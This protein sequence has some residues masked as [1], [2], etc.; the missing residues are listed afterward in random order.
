[1]H[2]GWFTILLASIL[3]FIMYVWYKGR[4][5]KNRFY[6]FIKIDKYLEIMKDMSQDQSIPKYA[7]NLIFITNTNSPKEIESKILYS[8]LNKQPKRADIYWFVH[9][10]NVYEPYRMEYRLQELVPNII[11]R[12]DFH[13]GFKVEPRINLFFRQVIEEMV[14]NK[15]INMISRY[16][17]LKKYNI[18]SDFKFVVIDRIQTFDFDFKAFEQFIMDI[19]DILKRFG[20]SDVKAFGLDTS[21]VTIENVPLVVYNDK[22]LNLKRIV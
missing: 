13:L 16:E 3:L 7:T 6:Q 8:I 21:N 1:M 4:L 5:I 12:I 2:G 22:D 15:E 17:S 20:I 10:D 14:V 11:Y 19:Y 18:T 9:V